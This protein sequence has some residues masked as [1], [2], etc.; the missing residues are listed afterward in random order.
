MLSNDQISKIESNI[1]KMTAKSKIF[2]G[3]VPQNLVKNGYDPKQ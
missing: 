3:G 2:Y 1:K